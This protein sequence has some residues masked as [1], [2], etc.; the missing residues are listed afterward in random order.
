MSNSE[1]WAMAKGSD[2][3]EVSNMGRIRSLTR[4]VKCGPSNGLRLAPGVDLKPFI[5]AKT[6]YFQVVFS[7]RKK[8]SVHR[9]VAHA[10]CDGY[11]DGLVVNHKNGIKT[12][13][14]A[15]NLE[16]ITSSQNIQHAFSSLGRK[17]SGA[18]KFGAKH[19]TSKAIVMTSIS[20]GTEE[21]FGC[22]LDAVRKFPD[23]DSGGISR[24]CNGKSKSHKG[25]KFRFSK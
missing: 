19:Q 18:G 9:L 8:H 5:N 24:C 4:I 12:D 3:H 17:G 1:I 2:H 15:S 23:L 16:W 25:Y 10:F 11:E 20:N 14:R 7:D 6:G 13:N 22:A 21:Y